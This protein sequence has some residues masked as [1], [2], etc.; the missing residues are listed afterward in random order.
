MTGSRRVREEEGLIPAHTG[1]NPDALFPRKNKTTAIFSSLLFIDRTC[2]QVE[3]LVLQQEHDG[4]RTHPPPVY[5]ANCVGIE[6]ALQQ[7]VGTRHLHPLPTTS[8]A[9]SSYLLWQEEV[10]DSI[11][12]ATRDIQRRDTQKPLTIA[13]QSL[14]TVVSIN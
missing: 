7:R 1:I 14:H 6:A 11:R 2:T 13:K 4:F 12:V 3:C 8:H 5:P 9:V 10:R